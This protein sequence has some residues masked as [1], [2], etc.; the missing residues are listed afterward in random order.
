MGDWRKALDGLESE[1]GQEP[2]SEPEKKAS[3]FLKRARNFC[4]HSRADYLRKKNLLPV[5]Q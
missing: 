3:D 5:L 2:A 4:R 1:S